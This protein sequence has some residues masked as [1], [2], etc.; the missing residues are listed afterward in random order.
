MLISFERPFKGMTTW[1]PLVWRQEN[2]RST[3]EFYRSISGIQIQM[4]AKEKKN[5][6]K[7]KT[8]PHNMKMKR[9]EKEEER[10]ILLNLWNRKIRYFLDDV[11]ELVNNHNDIYETNYRH[12]WILLRMQYR[13]YTTRLVN[14]GLWVRCRAFPY[15]DHHIGINKSHLR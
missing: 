11:R 15:R 6:N 10:E 4:F 9:K 5:N 3:R 8:Y 12:H 13:S 7:P 1:S 14:Q 2:C